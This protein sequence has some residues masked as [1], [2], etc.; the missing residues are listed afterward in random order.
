MP[1]GLPIWPT[2]RS[3]GQ[4]ASTMSTRMP[5]PPIDPMTCRRALAVRPPRPMTVPRSSGLTRTSSRCPRRESTM[6]TRTSSGWSTMPLTRCSSAGRSTSGLRVGAGTG[7]LLG[8]RCGWHVAGHRG[9]RL[10]GLL[11]GLGLLLRRLRDAGRG[12]R[13][14]F[15]GRAAV[16]LLRSHLQRLGRG[17]QALELLP[18]AGLGQD[19]LDS[20]AQ[21][22]ADRE[23]VLNPLGVDLDARGLLLRVVEPDELDRPAVTLGA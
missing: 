16:G 22:R 13:L 7:G 21:L 23:P 18:V 11:P 17:R 12:L 14:G 2:T 3:I 5:R 10:G 9:W 6:R 1:C 8:W 19:R 4:Y 20:L 15:V